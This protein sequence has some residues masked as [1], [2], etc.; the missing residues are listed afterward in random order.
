MDALD[1]RSKNKQTLL[2]K[3]GVR[4]VLPKPVTLNRLAAAVAKALED[5]LVNR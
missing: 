4:H 2:R 5:R 3:I 1:F